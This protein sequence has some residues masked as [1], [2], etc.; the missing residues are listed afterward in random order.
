MRPVRAVAWE[1]RAAWATGRRVSVSVSAA[2]G[3][4]R[5]EGLVDSVAASGAFARIGSHHVPLEAVL[6]VH[7]PSR[8]GDA[9]RW[10]SRPGRARKPVPPRGQLALP[11]LGEDP[12]F[13]SPGRAARRQRRVGARRAR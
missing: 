11:G 13:E 6:A 8:L 5:L 3:V 12:P 1:L 2:D 4:G 9:R 7:W 10:G